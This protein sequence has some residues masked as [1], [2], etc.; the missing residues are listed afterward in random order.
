M[1]KERTLLGL[2]LHIKEI[3]FCPFVLLHLNIMRLSKMENLNM[4]KKQNLIQEGGKQRKK[5]VPQSEFLG[6]FRHVILQD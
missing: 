4:T 2:I 1:T 5:K 3:T 6:L